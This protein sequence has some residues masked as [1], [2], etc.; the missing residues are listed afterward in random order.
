VAYAER[1]STR[2]PRPASGKQWDRLIAI[3]SDMLGYPLVNEKADFFTFR[4]TGA[5]N[6]AQMASKTSSTRSAT[7]SS[8]SASRRTDAGGEHDG[9]YECRDRPS[10][11]NFKY[12]E[13]DQI[14]DRWELP[15]KLPPA[16]AHLV[17]PGSDLT[18]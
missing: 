5:T 18:N 14:I 17:Q 9:G 16:V 7:S 6:L 3:A 10:Y 8:R 11:F 15:K 4:H 13:D 1:E 12:D 2:I